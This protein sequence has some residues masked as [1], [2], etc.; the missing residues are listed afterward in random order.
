MKTLLFILLSFVA[1]SATLSGL[2]LMSNPDS[3]IV[4]LPYSL[5]D[6][7]P[8]KDFRLPGILLTVMIGGINFLAVFY[9]LQR[10][11]NRYNWAICGGSITIA[12]VLIEMVL[13]HAFYWLQVGYLATGMLIVLLAYQLKGKW[14]V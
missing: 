1:V 7:T 6:G 10:H 8:F 5:L 2:W 14:A 13:N 3:G 11:R 9:N 4:K 12:W